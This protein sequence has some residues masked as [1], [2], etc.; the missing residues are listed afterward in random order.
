MISRRGDDQSFQRRTTG[1]PESAEKP[2]NG[3]EAMSIAFN[4]GNGM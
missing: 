4:T 2:K 1:S 3:F